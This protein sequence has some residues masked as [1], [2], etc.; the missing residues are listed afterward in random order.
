MDRS[1]EFD[2]YIMKAASTRD[3]LLYAGLRLFAE[4]GYANV[5]IRELCGSV[6]IKESS[7]YNHY[8]SK[9]SLFS[10]IVAFFDATTSQAMMTDDEIEH[11]I[12]LGDVE[13]FLT[14]NMHRFTAA[15]SNTLFFTALQIVLT[16]SFYN[17]KA[18]AA[19]K[20]NIYYLRKGY[21]ER[22]LRG[23]MQQGAI[24]PCDVETV[25]AEYYY[26]LKGILDEYLLLHLWDDDM[27]AI[28][29][30]IHAHIRFFVQMLK[31][32]NDE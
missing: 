5:G 31:P 11:W 23:L 16:E 32:E 9:D 24:R 28:N 22:I 17:P 29:A 26:A 7:F 1:E 15:T 4:K 8:K 30:R 13:A 14:G 20:K 6:H 10:A 12:S 27:T 2:R 25:T 3:K 21:T 19:A 18:A